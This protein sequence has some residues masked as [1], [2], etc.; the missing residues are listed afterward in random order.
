MTNFKASIFDLFAYII[1]GMVVIL[2]FVVAINSD[3][4]GIGDLVISLQ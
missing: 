3:I 1:P 4:R 2:A